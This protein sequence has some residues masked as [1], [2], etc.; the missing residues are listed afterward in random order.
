MK[1]LQQNSN[2]LPPDFRLRVEVQEKMAL[3]NQLVISSKDEDL[4]RW[5]RNRLGE[6]FKVI[7]KKL[8]DNNTKAAGGAV[9]QNK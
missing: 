7:Q 1:E 5:L 3:I 4:L 2:D 9:A 6:P 8:D